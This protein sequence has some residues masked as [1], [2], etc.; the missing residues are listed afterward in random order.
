LC[1]RKK[2][3]AGAKKDRGRR[4]PSSL[5]ALPVDGYQ[6][7]GLEKGNHGTTGKVKKGKGTSKGRVSWIAFEGSRGEIAAVRVRGT[8]K[9]EGGNGSN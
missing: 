5:R 4:Y 9:I 8:G 7:R 6:G 3:T 2:A 1:S